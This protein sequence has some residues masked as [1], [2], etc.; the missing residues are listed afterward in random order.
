MM[1]IPKTLLESQTLLIDSC[2]LFD[3]DLPEQIFYANAYENLDW[4]ELK[5]AQKKLD[6]ALS[7][8]EKDFYITPGVLDEFGYLQEIISEKLRFCN[9][10]LNFF[11]SRDPPKRHLKL[12]KKGPISKRTEGYWKMAEEKTT[13]GR[14]RE[15]KQM[16]D[17][18]GLRLLEL[19]KGL[20]DKVIKP[21]NK[22]AYELIYEVVEKIFSDPWEELFEHRADKELIAFTLYLPLEGKSPDLV[23]ADAGLGINLKRCYR[24][25]RWHR[26]PKLLAFFTEVYQKHPFRFWQVNREER[27]VKLAFQAGRKMPEERPGLSRKTEKYLEKKLIRLYESYRDRLGWKAEESYRGIHPEQG[28]KRIGPLYR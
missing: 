15:K 26:G 16:L 22:E 28:E 10:A 17:E 14:K 13:Y 6:D 2:I 19:K 9:K 8:L 5:K 25:L 1:R 11:E 21:E 27:L 12:K 3:S 4:K 7:F 23:S 24:F 18:I 20:R